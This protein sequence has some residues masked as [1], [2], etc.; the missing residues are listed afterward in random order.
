MRI[1]SRLLNWCIIITVIIVVTFLWQCLFC[2]SSCAIYTLKIS[3]LRIY[4]VIFINEFVVNYCHIAN[5]L[6]QQMA[7]SN[8]LG[9]GNGTTSLFAF[10]LVRTKQV[11]WKKHGSS[12]LM[13]QLGV[14]TQENG[15]ICT[16]LISLKWVEARFR[17]NKQY[18]YC[19]LLYVRHTRRVLK[20]ICA[21]ILKCN[22][23][24]PVKC[25]LTCVWFNGRR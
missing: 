9:K 6:I 1:G 23:H 14:C 22:H 8:L 5:P 24:L 17:S 20:T 13:F 12:A 18:L 10:V 19:V 21:F 2:W 16:C 11:M 4:I 7:A 25:K 15:I 3:V